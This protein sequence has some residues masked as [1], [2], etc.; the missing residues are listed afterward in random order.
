MKKILI[1]LMIIFISCSAA[2]TIQGN[3]P[4]NIDIASTPDSI[5]TVDEATPDSVATPLEISKPTIPSTIA[6]TEQP[7][8]KPTEA[9][10]YSPPVEETQIFYSDE[11]IE[12]YDYENNDNDDIEIKDNDSYENN[13]IGSSS[14]SA[15]DRSIIA[16]LIMAESGGCSLECLWLTGST[17]L[18]LAD[19]YHN[20][21]IEAT[22]KDSDIF[23]VADYLDYV[24]P[25]QE[26]WDTADRLLSGDRDYNVMAFR[27]D[28]YH[29][30]GTP[31][32]KVD[33]VYFSIY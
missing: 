9:S 7:T 20:G 3:C 6:P 21:D 11:N 25:N 10:T 8:D 16:R 24:E 17:L 31:Y 26:C 32:R 22:A 19:R 14:F 30:F 4:D 33:N 18:N 15:S 13:D 29:S 23:D 27:T 2:I 28:Y 1:F 5:A 12:N